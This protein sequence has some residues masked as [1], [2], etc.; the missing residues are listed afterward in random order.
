MILITG[1]GGTCGR[2]LLRQM[3][4]AGVPF[5]AGYSTAAKTEEAQ[6][7]DIDAVHANFR[8]P[9][10]L[11]AAL[12]GIEA[13]FLL[14]G[15]SPDQTLI[16][17]NLVREAKRAGV[18]HIVKLSVWDAAG[19]AFS[20]A[21]IHR[22]VEKE[23]EESGVAWTFLRPNG[24]MQNLSNFLAATVRSQSTLFA[25]ATTALVSHVDVRDVA[26]VAAAALT[27]PGHEGKSYE[28]SGPEALTYRQM[29]S[30]LSDLLGRTITCVEV[31]P[32]QVRAQMVAGGAPAAYAEAVNDL[33]RYYA[34]GHAARISPDVV[35]VTGRDPIP[36]DVFARDYIAAFR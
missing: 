29:A 2:E 31:T 7:R 23:I 11:A 1:A 21:R 24:F 25:P 6:R 13:L 28:L 4:D 16:E 5:R 35:R 26:R 36:F 33:T 34:E 9:E 14:C 12:R 22:P 17:M 18:R 30:T 8:Q 15:W 20:F 19:E 32:D 10:T 3:S 27:Q